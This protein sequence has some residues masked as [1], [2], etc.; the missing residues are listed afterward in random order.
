VIP[1]P[2]PLSPANR[3]LRLILVTPGIFEHGYR[4]SQLEGASL[5]A[6]A[7]GRPETISGWDHARRCPKICRRMAPAGSVYWIELDKGIDPQEWINRH[8]MQ[9]ISDSPQDR[10]DGFGLVMI[11]V[12]S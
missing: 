4:P 2:P 10:R 11:G 3:R 6:A 8:W 5:I 12:G 1:P 7:V 9:S